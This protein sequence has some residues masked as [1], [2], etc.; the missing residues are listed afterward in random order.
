MTDATPPHDL[1]GENTPALAGVSDALF[2]DVRQLIEAAQQ[3]MAQAVNSALTL[4]QWN[5]GNR[6][7]RDILG[8]ERAEYGEQ[9]VDN[10]ARQ[11]TREYGRGYE[12]KTLRRMIQFAEVFP[13]NQ[14]VATIE[15]ES[16][17]RTD[18]FGKALET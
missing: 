7:R 2:Q 16:F 4:L 8:Q 6:I 1:P 13:R 17:C 10:L 5:I 9:V 3:Q 11:L 12:P 15:L 18:S 14:T